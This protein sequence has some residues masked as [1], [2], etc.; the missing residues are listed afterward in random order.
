[1]K[2]LKRMI[3]GALGRF[4]DGHLGWQFTEKVIFPATATFLGTLMVDRARRRGLRDLLRQKEAAKQ[5]LLMHPRLQDIP[6]P[7]RAYYVHNLVNAFPATAYYSPDV[8]AKAIEHRHHYGTY[9]PD[10]IKALDQI[11]ARL[12]ESV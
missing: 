5:A 2:P 11:E 6:H 7:E 1:M 4:L 8:V 3:R 12:R 10:V 9:S